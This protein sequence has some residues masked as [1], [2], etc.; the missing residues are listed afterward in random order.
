MLSQI[1]NFHEFDV[2]PDGQRFLIGTVIGDTKAPAPTVLLNWT[3]LVQKRSSLRRS[4]MFID[5]K[6]AEPPAP[7]AKFFS[8]DDSYKHFTPLGVKNSRTANPV[9]R[10]PKC[11]RVETD[12]ALLF[13]RVDGATLVSTSAGLGGEPGT[14][15]LGAPSGPTEIQNKHSSSID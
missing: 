2:S 1:V 13:C 9:K 12:H 5:P 7:S 11:N 8:L 10:C 6:L 14:A 15:K 3:A 4:E